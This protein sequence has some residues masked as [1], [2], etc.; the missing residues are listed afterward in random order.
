[1]A[2]LREKIEEPRV[3]DT[4]WRQRFAA[5]HNRLPAPV[6]A[7]A[8]DYENGC[9][10][11]W[12]SHE[13]G[14]LVHATSGV[15]RVLTR[16]GAWTVPPLHALWIA[17]GVDHELHM[18]GT[19]RMRALYV[20]PEMLSEQWQECRLIKIEALLRELILALLSAPWSSDDRLITPLLLQCLENARTV[21]GCNLPLPRDK[22]L[23]KLCEHL[24]AN[25]AD[26]ARMEDWSDR[27]GASVRTLSRRFRDETGLSFIQ[28]RQQLRIAEAVCLLAEG[29]PLGNIARDMGYANATAFSAMFKRV[30][31]E[32]PSRYLQTLPS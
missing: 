17:P 21:Q 3:L 15:V 14:Q 30:L 31:G 2:R 4:I 27:I 11:I 20:E 28:W 9:R 8:H 13:Y 16:L 32:V 26:T 6:V 22:R 29:H 12:H 24:L 25:P 1:M 19:V 7:R 5:S 10:E 18:I 23:L